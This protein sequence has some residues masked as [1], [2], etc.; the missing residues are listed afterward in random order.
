[1]IAAGTILRLRSEARYRRLAGEGVVLVQDDSMAVGLNETALRFLELVDGE[2]TFGMILSRLEAEYAA[3][4]DVIA[5]DFRLL[6]EELIA[7]RVCEMVPG[8]P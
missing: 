1:M 5:T 8:V 3:P 7:R 2:A 4:A 6:A